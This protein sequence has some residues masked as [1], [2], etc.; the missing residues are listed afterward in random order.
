LFLV[1]GEGYDDFIALFTTTL[2]AK[3]ETV[4]R[5]YKERSQ[6][7]QTNKELKSYLGLKKAISEKGEELWLC[8]RA[9]FGL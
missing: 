4:I 1:K 2:N 7:E 5:K 9:L 3:P 6:I 8:F